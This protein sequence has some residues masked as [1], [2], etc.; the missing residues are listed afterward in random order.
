MVLK[1]FNY[2]A[3]RKWMMLMKKISLFAATCCL[4][5]ALTAHAAE[6]NMGWSI[7]LMALDGK[8]VTDEQIDH[9]H[10]KGLTAGEHQIVFRY[11]NSLR[12]GQTSSLLKTSPYVTT[13][14]TGQDDIWTFVVPKFNTYSQ[15]QAYFR[16]TK[17]VRWSLVNQ[18]GQEQV[19]NYEKLPGAGFMPFSDIE[20]PLAAYN[21][22]KENR[23]APKAAKRIL[24]DETLVDTDNLS[25]INMVK[26]LYV[27]ASEK[28]KQQIKA[29]IAQKE[30]QK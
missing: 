19:L 26:L 14:K 20:K 29:W 25:L 13:I 3:D 10:F 21:L 6:L 16:R 18:H 4:L 30:N 24:I 28:Q 15:A 2:I 17:D 11:V 9:E 5:G 23:F 8:G 22:G 12:D 27:N 7:E 1:S